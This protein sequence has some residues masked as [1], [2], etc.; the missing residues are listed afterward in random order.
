MYESTITIKI[1]MKTDKTILCGI[2][3][4][5]MAVDKKLDHLWK[6]EVFVCLIILHNNVPAP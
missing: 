3:K 6:Y 4:S 1:L 5:L 2:I